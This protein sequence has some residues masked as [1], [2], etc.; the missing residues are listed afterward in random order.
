MC[1]NYF[2]PIP[3]VFHLNLFFCL[4]VV[5]SSDVSSPVVYDGS[6]FTVLPLYVTFALVSTIYEE[7]HIKSIFSL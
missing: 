1:A 2:T 6:S 3:V 5:F 4:L 7:L